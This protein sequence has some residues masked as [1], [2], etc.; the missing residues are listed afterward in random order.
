MSSAR[1]PLQLTILV[2]LTWTGLLLSGA[3]LTVNIAVKAAKQAILAEIAAGGG[4]PAV[5][6]HAANFCAAWWFGGAAALSTRRRGLYC[7]KGAQP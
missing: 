1:V 2:F 3:A 6:Q 7:G 5:Q 4:S